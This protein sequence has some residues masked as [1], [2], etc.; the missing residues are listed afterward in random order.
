[1]KTQ[2]LQDLNENGSAQTG[3]PP[4][5][6]DQPGA[7][8]APRASAAEPVRQAAPVPPVVAPEP[9]MHAAPVETLAP[10]QPPV[11]PEPTVRAESTART[12]PAFRTEP[13]DASAAAVWH[14]P[15]QA[16]P[17]PPPPEPQ[18]AIRPR[19]FAPQPLPPGAMFPPAA[20]GGDP[21][22]LT[23]R[24]ARSA[25]THE[26]PEWSGRWTRRLATWGTA[27]VLLAL[28]ASG[29]LWLYQQS[30]V[31]GA[32]TVVAN[33]NPAPA[34][35]VA[36]TVTPG[37][38][39]AL[40]ASAARNESPLSNLEGPLRPTRP[41][42]AAMPAPTSPS[43]VGNSTGAATASSAGEAAERA[44]TPTPASMDPAQRS[45]ATVDLSK[46][47]Q[48]D[49]SPPKRKRSAS[50]KH[51]KAQTVASARESRG[52]SERE[53]E[54]QDERSYRQRYEETLMQCRAHGYD[55]RQCL[56]RGCEMTRY[57]FACKG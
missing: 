48:A 2:L 9:V 12:E 45:V 50:R 31:E 5:A 54:G 23:E 29:G 33:T 1:M 42:A 57:G 53:G 24:L 30:R 44:P 36:R 28:V 18:H 27:G 47:G 51:P 41:N 49:I 55:E 15:Q 26:R 56:Q 16:Q 39:P 22:W 43:A 19:G 7:P 10:P 25:A 38:L 4:G 35:R 6:V 11:P 20:G 37:S 34:A 40:P 32:L 3:P 52:D 46:D 8:G 13:L 14:R 21:D 17:V